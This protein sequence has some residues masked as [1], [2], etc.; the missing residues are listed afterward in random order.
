MSDGPWWARAPRPWRA[1]LDG[2]VVADGDDTTLLAGS[3]AVVWDVLDGPMTEDQIV[4]ACARAYGLDA[5]A[6]GTALAALREA[7]LCTTT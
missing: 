5:G 7:G 6:V 1:T 3:A 4:Q 2:I